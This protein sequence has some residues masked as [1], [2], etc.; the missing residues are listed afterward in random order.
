VLAITLA[1]LVGDTGEE[2]DCKGQDHDSEE[3][4]SLVKALVVGDVRTHV[5]NTVAREGLISAERPLTMR[6]TTNTR[7][8]TAD[9]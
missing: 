7:P 6:R 2:D 4:R 9:T 1:K 3:D 8:E 5:I